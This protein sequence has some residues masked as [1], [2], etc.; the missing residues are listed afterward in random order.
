MSRPDRIVAAAF[1]VLAGLLLLGAWLLPPGIGRLPGPG[2]FPGS[3]GGVM[4]ALS[5][6]LLVR[7]SA[8]ESAGSLLRGDLRL[9]GIAA[10]ITFAYLA[11]WGS[12][13]FFLRTVLFLYLF[14]RILGEKPRAGA[15]VALVLT[16]AV[17]LAF[18]YGLHVSL[19]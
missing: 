12:G 6:A 3:I 7:P 14:L 16:A 11:L 13:F 10:L 2:F 1:A 19:E 5:V 17:T 15:A 18:Q 9:A 8:A 4:L